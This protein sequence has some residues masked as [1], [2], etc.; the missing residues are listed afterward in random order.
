MLSENG[1]F[2]VLFGR[3]KYFLLVPLIIHLP[4]MVIFKKFPGS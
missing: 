4:S 3:W 1:V 2:R